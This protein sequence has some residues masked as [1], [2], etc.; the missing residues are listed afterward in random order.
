MIL[1]RFYV[2]AENELIYHYCRPEAF[3]EII[4][5][6]TIWASAY[7]ALN[8]STER[9]WGHSMFVKAADALRAQAG[10]GFM[11]KMGT[12]VTAAHENSIV[13]IASYS[14]DADVLSQWRAYAS[15]GQ[16]FAIGFSATQIKMAAKPSRVLYDGDLQFKELLGNL[17]HVYQY[18]KSLGFKYDDQFVGHCYKI[19]LDLCAYKNPAFNEEKEIRYVHVTGLHP[20]FKKIIA[21]GA[22]G[23]DGKRI[24]PPSKVHFRI[25]KGVVVPYVALDYTNRST[26]SPIKEVILGPRN[27]NSE[28][29]I[30]VFLNTLGIK[31]VKVRRSTVPYR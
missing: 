23:H 27:E 29:N 14:L 21:A 16:G 22:R 4:S 31:D 15:D 10:E 28:L 25:S 8:D 24:A 20:Q 3:L 17:T 12:M 9:R 18:E 26:V 7:F 1:D 2:P 13:M 19:G 11:N 5:S 30:E 6:R